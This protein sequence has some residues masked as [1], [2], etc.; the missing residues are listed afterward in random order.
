MNNSTKY[1]ILCH[2]PISDS[3]ADILFCNRQDI[4]GETCT[5]YDE[6]LCWIFSIRSFYIDYFV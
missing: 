5:N 2:L 3:F 4:F 6:G 1:S